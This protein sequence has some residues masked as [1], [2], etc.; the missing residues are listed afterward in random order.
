M[1]YTPSGSSANITPYVLSHYFGYD[2]DLMQDVS[3]SSFTQ[4][5]WNALIDNEL[6]ANARYYILGSLPQ[7]DMSLFVMALMEMDCIISI[8][9]GVVV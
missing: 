6:A 8:G 3:R 4:A 9:D 2:A 7:A 1:D 5:Q